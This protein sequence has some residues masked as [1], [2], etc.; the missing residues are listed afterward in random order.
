LKKVSLRLALSLSLPFIFQVR[1]FA[2]HAA[3]IPIS[4]EKT[5]PIF[6]YIFIMVGILTV[7][8]IVMTLRLTRKIKLQK[9]EAAS[10]EKTIAMRNFFMIASIMAAIGFVSSGFFYYFVENMIH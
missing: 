3:T 7:I 5:F 1:A 9:S 2:D 6:L 8:G 4:P 10:V